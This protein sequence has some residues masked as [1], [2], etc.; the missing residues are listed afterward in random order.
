MKK[1]L[2]S[3]RVVMHTPPAMGA[4]NTNTTNNDLMIGGGIPQNLKPRPLTTAFNRRNFLT[5]AGIAGAGVL[6]GAP[7]SQ[8]AFFGLT[9]EDT[10]LTM[11]QAALEGVAFALADG[12]DVLRET[13]AEID[14]LSVIGGGSRSHWWGQ[15][16]AS[17]M[18]RPLTYR[19]ASAVG[20]AFGAARLARLR[21]DG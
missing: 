6:I 18:D 20:P 16:I 7:K 14:S 21:P 5:T 4:Q 11:A 1:S 17:A 15:I 3:L 12:V 10:P 9:H 2:V 13:G 19:K 8:G